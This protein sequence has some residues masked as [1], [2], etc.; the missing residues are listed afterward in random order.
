MQSSL[1]K[2]SQA[3]IR[4]VRHVAAFDFGNDEHVE[5][6]DMLRLLGQK[7]GSGQSLSYAW[8]LLS[9]RAR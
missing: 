3:K 9:D 1:G 5:P 4:G 7:R 8:R 2:P 6:P